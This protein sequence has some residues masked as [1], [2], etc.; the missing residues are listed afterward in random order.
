MQRN[1]SIKI[2]IRGIVIGL[3][4]FPMM[5][6][7]MAYIMADKFELNRS[8]LLLKDMSYDWCIIHSLRA[9]NPE[10]RVMRAAEHA[11][12]CVYYMDSRGNK[13][14][15]KWLLG[16]YMPLCIAGWNIVG[17]WSSVAIVMSIETH[18]NKQAINIFKWLTLADELNKENLRKGCYDN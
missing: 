1:K 11:A 13:L 16:L 3:I 5:V 2:A 18:V 4:I 8:R 17:E 10:D 6:Y 12:Y 15:E 14:V 7:L 9:E